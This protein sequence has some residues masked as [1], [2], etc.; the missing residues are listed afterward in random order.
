MSTTVVGATAAETRLVDAT[1]AET[2]LVDATAA[3][4][5]CN[6]IKSLTHIIVEEFNEI[7]KC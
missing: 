7:L 4:E 5:G 1:A 2:R 6:E 3:V